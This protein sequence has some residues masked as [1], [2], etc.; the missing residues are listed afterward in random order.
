MY[1]ASE[2]FHAAVMSPAVRTEVL[3]TFEDGTFLTAE[4]V[5]G[6]DVTYPLNEEIDLMM[7]ACVASELTATVMNHHGLLSGFKF[8]KSHLLLGAETAVEAW[9]MPDGKVSTVYGAYTITAHESVP[10]LTVNGA[11]AT[12]Q[13]AFSPDSLVLWGNIL[14]AGSKSGTLWVG[15]VQE[16][17]TVI[18]HTSYTVWAALQGYTWAEVASRT[19]DGLLESSVSAFLARKISKWAGR[20][21]AYDGNTH[22]EY[23]EDGV[24]VYEYVPLGVFFVDTPEVRRAALID[25]TAL[26]GMSRFDVDC[27][28]WWAGLLWPMTRK[29]LLERL[30]D[31]C[32]VTL[33][34]TS[35]LGSGVSVASAPI[36]GNGITGRD[37]LGWIAESACAYGRMSRDGKLELVW[38]TAQ[39]VTY[40][41]GEYFRDDYAEYTVPAIA[42]LHVMAMDSDLGVMV[43]ANASGNEYQIIDNP[44]LYGES[45]T[46]IRQKSDGIFTRLSAFGTYTPTTVEAKADWSVESGDIIAVTDGEGTRSVPVFHSDLHWAGGIVRVTLGCTGN[47]ERKPADSATRAEFARYRA[48]HRLEVDISGM[49]SE[50]GDIEGNVATLEVTASKLQVQI[51]GKAGMDEVQSLV[52]QTASQLQTQING[53]INGTEAKSLINQTIDKIELSVS[54][55]SGGSTFTLTSDGA[56]ISSEKVDLHVKSVNVDGT[57]T[58]DAINLNTATVTGTLSASY[59]SGGTL[60]F[61]DITAKNLNVTNANIE[62]LYAGKIIGGTTGGYLASNAISDTGRALDYLRVTTVNVLDDLYL[63]GGSG[64]VVILTY[65]GVST[66]TYSNVSWDTILAG[67][68]SAVFG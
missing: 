38:F 30:C 34:T 8:G 23:E 58:A 49:H 43:P 32:G 35:F 56:T 3:W 10:Y 41:Q 40:T 1:Q 28:D 61:N 52:T 33:A 65:S 22:R 4:D 62:S 50:I 39:D 57:I 15:E 27:D 20:G 12:A 59:I 26:D 13:P 67:N 17:G 29:Q 45:E 66:P 6:V 64:N 36:A 11:E 54:S 60:D 53:K 42:A 31:Y 25:V 5:Q 16:D 21:I 48:Y 7:G 55:G 14:Y 46:E 63:Y 19:W 24:H 18:D 44:L 9:T 47:N 2:A 68:S 37:V 51:S